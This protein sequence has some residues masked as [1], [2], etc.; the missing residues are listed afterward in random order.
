MQFERELKTQE[1]EP[2]TSGLVLLVS[3]QFD[4]HVDF[5]IE[6]LRSE[7]IQFARFNTEDFPRNTSV[8]L[9]LG[10]GETSGLLD[11][12]NNLPFLLNQTRSILYR[13]PA[14]PN[15]PDNLTKG[16][17]EFVVS[18]SKS[19]IKGLWSLPD[20]TWVNYPEDNRRAA[21]KLDQLRQAQ[22][23]GLSIPKTLVSNNIIDI[24]SFFDLCHGSMIVKPLTVG[25]IEEDGIY[26]AFYTSKVEPEHLD[27]LGPDNRCPYVFQENIPKELE[28][29]ITIVGNSVFAAEIFSQEQEGAETDWRKKWEGL[30]YGIHELPEDIKNKC[31]KLARHYNLNFGAIDMIVTPR[32]EY[33]FLEINPNGQWVWIEL[34]TGL[35]IS[36]A[37]IK[38]LSEN[39]H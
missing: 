2:G 29:R 10:D 35:P 9:Y 1:I 7:N 24:R 25:S 12:P 34:E 27:Q 14:E 3:R 17:E 15:P 22:I 8:S 36:E 5:I 19:V 30:R 31:L 18:E 13:R 26:K 21:I 11:V 33:V 4:P 37:M 23:L 16:F 28:L 32:G 38:L 20:V 39:K 6:K